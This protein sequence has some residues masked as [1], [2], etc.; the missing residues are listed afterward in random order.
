MKI[1]QQDSDLSLNLNIQ[2]DFKLDLG[3]ED[4]LKEF[5]TETL[6]DVINPIENYET[7]RFIHQ[8]YSGISSNPNDLQSDIWFQFYFYNNL[9]PPTH[10]GGMNYEFV[11]ISKSENMKMLKQA[12]E[13]FFR[14]EF[15]KVPEGEKPEKVNRR[16]VFARNLSLP[17]GERV[18]GRVDD[19]YQT[20]EDWDYLYVPIFVGS[21]YRN[22]ENMYIFWF[23]DDTSF[24]AEPILTGNTFFMSARFFNADD[25]TIINFANKDKLITDNISENDD[26]YFEVEIDKSDYSYQVFRYDGARGDRIGKS[27]NPIKF[28]EITGGA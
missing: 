12:T 6:K 27:G 18:L 3:R 17:L 20:V 4:N 24:E 26:I 16:L 10:F 28:Y 19:G 8:P 21:N 5:E 13:S 25:G 15:Y 22:K 2:T 9:T 23:Q 14:L 11:G 7:S 1:V